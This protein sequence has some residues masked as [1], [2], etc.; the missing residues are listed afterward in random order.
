MAPM[1]YFLKTL[2]EKY[3]NDIKRYVTQYVTRETKK[4]LSEG[5]TVEQIKEAVANSKNHRLPKLDKKPKKDLNTP[6]KER[7]KRLSKH[8]ESVQ[9]ITRTDGTQE[10]IK[11]YPWSSDPT[12]YFR[13][14]PVTLSI[15]E[16]TKDSCLMP[17]IYLDDECRGCRYFE[18]CTCKIKVV[19]KIKTK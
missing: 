12:G 14:T 9:V 18:Q 16:V 13:S 19:P 3:D 17:H 1:A 7:K 6:K 15:A 2:K 10:V 4:Y 5:W 11:T 8:V